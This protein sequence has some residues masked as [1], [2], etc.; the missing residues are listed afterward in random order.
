MENKIE[1]MWY[2]NSNDKVWFRYYV[3]ENLVVWYN[4]KDLYECLYI[5]GR[6][7]EKLYKELNENNKQVLCDINNDYNKIEY[8]E[9]QFIN[10]EGIK[11]IESKV[12]ER[13]GVIYKNI[14][15][16]K[17]DIKKTDQ[18]RTQMSKDC[19]KEYIC[20]AIDNDALIDFTVDERLMKDI[21]DYEFN[22]DKHLTMCKKEISEDEKSVVRY[23]K[24]GTTCPL[25]IRDVIK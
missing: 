22:E 12:I 11:E 19:I 23:R 18:Y 17:Q 3:D 10:E 14:N 25:W 13:F 2:V 16:V 7:A 1:S 15:I 21:I 9:T 8:K 4:Y 24:Q 5:S 20:E 6:K